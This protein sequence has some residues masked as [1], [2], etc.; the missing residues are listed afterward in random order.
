[1]LG[2]GRRQFITLIGGAATAWPL[3]AGAQQT[4]FFRLGYLDAGARS[5]STVQSLRRQF[6]LGM[7]DLGYVEGRNFKMEERNADGQLDRL[8]ALAAELVR[9]PVD[10]IAAAGGEAPIH[11]ARQ[12][13][14]TLPIVM[15]I[16]AD[17]IGSGF[18]VS[19]GHPGGNITGMSSL[20]SDLGSKRVELVKEIVPE[21]KRVAVIWNSANVSKAAEWKET[22]A[23]AQLSGLNL[24]SAEV[25]TPS[26]LED[27]LV[28]LASQRPDAMIA[29]A[30]GLTI[31][32]R[33]RLGSFAL[34]SRLPLISA[35]REFVI[36]GAIASYGVSRPDLWRR[37]A[38]YVDKIARGVNPADLPVEQ[39]TRFEL[40]INLKSA[41]ALGID[42]PPA[43]FALAD[44]VIE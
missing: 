23:A 18:V 33:Q 14:S 38:I 39:P 35:L 2:I 24:Q 27:A 15:L 44:E 31:A 16:A 10:I 12:A 20:T 41:K 11:A 32:F 36:E 19:L 17:P 13:T 3:V 25:R 26:E 34:D 42:M 6:L 9:L 30:E 28:L 22:E 40:V 4:K 1:M 21:A 5:D 7:R 29:F 37:S 43:L 8:P